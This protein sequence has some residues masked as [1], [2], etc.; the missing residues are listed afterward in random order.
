MSK[1]ETIPNIVWNKI[2]ASAGWLK[3]IE[4]NGYVE[5]TSQEIKTISGEEA[6][7][8]TKFDQKNTLPEIFKK[9]KLS[10]LPT[11]RGTYRIGQF[12]LYEEFPKI[13]WENR[14]K[15]ETVT[16]PQHLH[17][18]NLDMMSSESVALNAAYSS[19]VLEDF[20]DDTHLLPT[21]SG[22]MG[23][24][25][26]E[27]QVN[28]ANKTSQS[29]KINKAQMEI[30]GCFE[31]LK[32]IALI[33]AKNKFATDFLIRQ[34]YYPY[35]FWIDK[36][37]KPVRPIFQIYS[38]ETLYLFEYEFLVPNTYNSIKLVKQ[39]Q[40]RF[41]DREINI[42]EISD[43]LN[44]T[45]PHSN[46]S[47]SFPQANSFERVISMLEKLNET[48]N[49]KQI[50]VTKHFGFDKR[51]TQY[52]FSALKFLGLA[53]RIQ[54]KEGVFYNLTKSAK[55][56][57]KLS[58]ADR[59]FGFIHKIISNDVFHSALTM[60]FE[61]GILLSTP[62]ARQLM[63]KFDVKGTDSDTTEKR[64]AESLIAWLKW[65]IALAQD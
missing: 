6:R 1:K 20:L 43:L 48:K 15:S 63:R 45:Q 44:S 36:V 59:Q 52:Y 34:L 46:K 19:G 14:L 38:N 24:G 12:N 25:Q 8:V 4:T 47:N 65:I 57:M 26:L 32:S 21:S 18:L 10:I 42:S 13:A 29:I 37:T 54:N 51:Q 28:L 33:E 16:L 35:K 58:Y 40:Y 11:A 3:Q 23:T 61:T 56:L 50:E 17:T 31:G 9:N 60:Y 27:F 55:D 7:L 30:D 2:F 49:T 22:R 5:I 39:R 53:V 41:Q 64:R 62:E